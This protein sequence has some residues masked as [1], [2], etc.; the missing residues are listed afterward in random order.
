MSKNLNKETEQTIF[1]VSLIVFQ[2]KGYAATKLQDIAKQANINQSL[3]HYYFRNKENL[4]KTVLRHKILQLFNELE[5]IMLTSQKNNNELNIKD[6]ILVYQ[7]FFYKNPNLPMFIIAEI[8]SNPKIMKEIFSV[9]ELET[10]KEKVIDKVS[11]LLKKFDNTISNEQ[12]FISIISIV[13]FP[14]MAKELLKLLFNKNDK[15]YMNFAKER[16]SM[17]WDISN[18]LL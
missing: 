4:F 5:S 10:F 9:T 15:E 1:D 3:L 13:V 6:L 18:K 16:S 8:N 12:I 11:A 17:I 7:D 14:F 2:K